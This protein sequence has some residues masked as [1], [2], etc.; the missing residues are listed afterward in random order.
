MSTSKKSA[1][2]FL[3]MHPLQ[4]MT[5]S[6]VLAVVT[7]FV[8]HKSD[9]PILFSII[10]SWCMFSF[11]Y[12]LTS[13]IILFTRS[14]DDIKRL[15]IADDGSRTLVITATVI[16]SFAAMVTVLILVVTSNEHQK[17]DW[18][19][20]LVCF[21]SVILSWIMVHTILTFHYAHLYYDCVKRG[22]ERIKGGLTFPGEALP[23]YLDFAYFSFIIGMTFQVSDVEITD[24]QIRRMALLHGLISFVLNTFVVA[25]TVNFIAGLSK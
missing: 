17:S 23:N 24:K 7:Y 15:A 11:T 8:L 12:V 16:A 25:L 21:V 13:W 9:D 2:I 10:A 3:K 1:N 22:D 20:V 18:A 5:L 19:T 14:I 4:R 6:L